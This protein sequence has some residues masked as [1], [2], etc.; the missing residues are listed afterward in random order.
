MMK[1]LFILALLLSA[2]CF[3]QTPVWAPGSTHVLQM[4]YLQNIVKELPNFHHSDARM[5]AL[6]WQ[7][8]LRITFTDPSGYSVVSDGDRHGPDKAP[9]LSGLPKDTVLVFIVAP[10]VE[11]K[12]TITKIERT[13]GV[14]ISPAPFL[15]LPF[16]V[17]V[18]K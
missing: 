8:T 16:A 18:T 3:A 17:M 5:A 9:E 6:P 10:T 13:D 15:G 4:S 11:G 14:H 1:R 7:V 2:H 12:Y